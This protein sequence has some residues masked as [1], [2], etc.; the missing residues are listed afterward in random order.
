MVESEIG[1]EVSVGAVINPETM[2]PLYD[3]AGRAMA[4]PP[5]EV[6]HWLTQGFLREPYDPE[7]SIAELEILAPSIIDAFRSLVDTVGEDGVIDT[8]ETA[9][10]ATAS[11]AQ[12][13]FNVTCSRILAGI[14]A[15]YPVKD[16]GETVA[17]IG[18]DSEGKEFET[19]VSE[20]QVENYVDQHGYRMVG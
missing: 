4:V 7:A 8:N 5:E 17:M 3:N 16:I 2:V 11:Q 20:D 10:M 13:L 18:V 9:Q 12:Q 1:N 19:V 15:R 14:N 6:D